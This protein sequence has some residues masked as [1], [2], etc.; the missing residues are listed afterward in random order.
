MGQQQLLLL[1]LGIIIVAVA[2]TVGIV[3]FRSWSDELNRLDMLEEVEVLRELICEYRSK[4]RTLG[5]GGGTVVDFAIPRSLK[6]TDE[7]TYEIVDRSD[8]DL[9]VLTHSA[10]DPSNGFRYHIHACSEVPCGDNTDI[11]YFG[12][13]GESGSGSGPAVSPPATTPPVSSPPSSSIQTGAASTPSSSSP[14]PALPS[15]QSG[16]GSAGT[17]ASS[18]SS[19]ASSSNSGTSSSTGNSGGGN[20]N[21][22]HHN[23]HHHWTPP[24]LVNKG[25]I[26]PGQAKKN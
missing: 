8:F 18:S 2:I 14:S 6:K 13:F 1:T 19:T 16:S 22:W 24:G 12:A 23:N 11:S 10:L 15:T 5:G 20:S 26:P 4:P 3:E 21:S 17:T 25:G 7:A 9:V